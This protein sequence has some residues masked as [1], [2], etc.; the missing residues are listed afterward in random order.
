MTGLSEGLVCFYYIIWM[1]MQTEMFFCY[2]L[3]DNDNKGGREFC[4]QQRAMGDE[5]Q[6]FVI[7]GDAKQRWLEQDKRQDI[8]IIWVTFAGAGACSKNEWGQI[9]PYRSMLFKE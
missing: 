6:H 1:N 3:V 5:G 9:F 7:A 2:S 8:Q 4:P